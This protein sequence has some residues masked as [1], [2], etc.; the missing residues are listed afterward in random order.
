MKKQLA[1][2][3]AAFLLM[4]GTASA[5]DGGVEGKVKGPL[6]L[7]VDLVVR[8]SGRGNWE[9]GQSGVGVSIGGEKKKKENT[10]ELQLISRATD[11][12]ALS[13]AEITAW[14]KDGIAPTDADIFIAKADENGKYAFTGIPEGQYFLVV[15]MPGGGELTGEVDKSSDAEELRKF[16][17]AWD[18]YQLSTIGM[19]LYAVQTIDVKPDQM[20]QFNYDFNARM[21]QERKKVKS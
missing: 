4:T 15:L 9:R 16:L 18:M 19:K 7:G 11:M 21:F 20:V 1:V 17:R 12:N 3:A 6:D 8:D 10:I 14:Y 13:E 2:M 5:A